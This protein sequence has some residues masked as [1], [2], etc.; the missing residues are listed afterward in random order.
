MFRHA[1]YEY[2][3]AQADAVL[4]HRENAHRMPPMAATATKPR[5][6]RAPPER[7]VLE[8]GSDRAVELV[9]GYIRQ[10]RR[11]RDRSLEA[12]LLALRKRH[13]RGRRSP[14]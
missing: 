1:M 13:A 14:L 2:V 3:R 7:E 6:R 9:R 12:T 8:A 10:Q 5:R 11:L 4:F